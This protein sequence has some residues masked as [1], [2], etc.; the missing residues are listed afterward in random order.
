MDMSGSS[1]QLLKEYADINVQNK[2]TWTVLIIGGAN[3]HAQVVE[4]LAKEIVDLD[5]HKKR[6][7]YSLN[8]IL[9]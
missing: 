5:A 7:K 8:V 4:L 9:S 3:G 2:E 6:W 1:K